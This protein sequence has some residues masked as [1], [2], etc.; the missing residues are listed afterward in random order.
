[1][2]NNDSHT[3]CPHSFGL[4]CSI[5]KEKNAGKGAVSFCALKMTL[6]TAAMGKGILT[7]CPLSSEAPLHCALQENLRKNEQCYETAGKLP[8]AEKLCHE[9][10]QKS[11]ASVWWTPKGK[12]H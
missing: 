1:M 2:H 3:H 10:E 7:N 8:W 5:D 4:V 6:G 12:A 11:S 9:E